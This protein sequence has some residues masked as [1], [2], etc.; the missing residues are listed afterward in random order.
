MK[1]VIVGIGNVGYHLAA[2]LVEE[3][4]DIVVIDSHTET[5]ERLVEVLDIKVVH[6]NGTYYDVQMEA[7]VPHADLVIAV[8]QRDEINMLCCLLA[9]KLGAKNTIARV[10]NL[11]YSRQ[12]HLLKDELGLSL[13]INPELAAASEIA[14]ILKI[15]LCTED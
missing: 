9:K 8:A 10:R 5:L 11:E 7:D 15:P 14:R 13:A 6:G 3:G 1:I 12:L 2:L 4:H